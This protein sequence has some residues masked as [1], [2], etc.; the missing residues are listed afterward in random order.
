MF[1]RAMN[2]LSNYGWK[3]SCLNN[4]QQVQARECGQI[5]LFVYQSTTDYKHVDRL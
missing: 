2:Y 1:C 5:K 3:P 4:F